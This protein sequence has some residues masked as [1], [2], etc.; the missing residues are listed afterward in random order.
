MIDGGEMG[1]RMLRT[2]LS[3]H[4]EARRGRPRAEPRT[5]MVHWEHTY[6]ERTEPAQSR[7]TTVVWPLPAVPTSHALISSCPRL[8][9]PSSP[10]RVA[11][12]P[13]F[14]FAGKHHDVSNVSFSI[15][16]SLTSSSSS[17]S[18][19]SLS[20]GDFT[21][22]TLMPSFASYTSNPTFF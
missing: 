2:D 10:R 6:R 19:S 4:T 5:K 9:S 7:A 16:F 3:L 21:P 15:L 11:H 13:S 17:A 18:S 14:C 12:R 20:L 8:R 1:M 22:S